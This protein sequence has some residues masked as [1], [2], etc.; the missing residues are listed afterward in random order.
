M[1]YRSF[2]LITVCIL[3][4]CLFFISLCP[5]SV[6]AEQPEKK[7][8]R[9]GWYDSAFNSVDEFGRRTG[10]GYEYQQKIAAYTGWDYEYVEGTWG[11]LFE[12]LQRGEIDILSDVSYT[13][14]RSGNM[15]FSSEPMGY[16]EYYVLIDAENT[17]IDPGNLL[18]LNGK[19]IGVNRGSLQENMFEKWLDEHDIDVELVTLSVKPS[20][21]V[22]MLKDK[23]LDAIVSVSSFDA[24]L[25]S[26]IPI[27]KIG[28]SEF[29]FA[30]NND[31]PDL[32]VELD[33]AMAQI[34]GGDVFYNRYLKEKYMSS[35][36]ILRFFSQEEK[37][38]LENHGPIRVGYR[39]EYLPFCD[40]NQESGELVGLLN[41]L[42]N[43]AS[44]GMNNAEIRFETYSY[45]TIQEALQALNSGE[46]DCLFPVCMSNYDAEVNDILITDT[47]LTSEVFVAYN[48]KDYDK[49]SQNNSVRAAVY[50]GNIDD[51]TVIKDN[52]PNWQWVVCDSVEECF[53]LVSE[54]RAECVIMSNYRTNILAEI[55]EKYELYT[56]STGIGM[57]FSFAVSSNNKVLYAIMEKLIGVVTDAQIH[58]SLAFYSL[59]NKRVTMA[60]FVKNNIAFVLIFFCIVCL[61]ICLMWVNSIIY[62]KKLKKLNAELMNKQKQLE[63]SSSGQEAQI[64][65]IK[66]LNE[67]LED[68]RNRAEAANKAK[69]S[70]L[71][72]MSHDIRTPMNAIV[73][74][75]ELILNH[76]DEKEKCID[77]TKK[78]KSSSD[79]LLSLINNVLEMA[80]IESGRIVLDEEPIQTGQIVGEVSAV[81]TELMKNKNIEFI[82]ELDVSTKYIYADKVKL[83][84]IFLN[85]VSNAYKYTPEGG[86]VF[87]TRRELPYEKEGYVM[88]ETVVSDTGIG[89]SKDFIPKIFEEF[90]RE[91]KAIDSRIQ[92]AGLGMPI[93]KRLVELMGGTITVESEI[94]KG[95]TFIVNIPHRIASVEDMHI[96]EAIAVEQ[97]KFEG[98]KILLAE[99][100]DLN[101]EIAK[102]ILEDAGFKVERAADGIICIDMLRKAK[103]NYYDLILMD[104]QMPNMDGYKA[105]RFIR[106]MEDADK[107]NIPIVA[108]TANAFEEDR[109]N[110]LAAGMNE[111]VA[112]PLDIKKLM[113]TLAFILGDCDIH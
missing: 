93:V 14:E 10:Y 108:M 9:I 7:K 50:K 79:F 75:T 18:T 47:V 58:S 46:I 13:E 106:S 2:R 24:Y 81:Y 54:D 49:F 63:E 42:I 43:T 53:K 105:T 20:E 39:E 37:E 74:Y 80:R 22:K 99:D 94:G 88:M 112:K 72:N 44:S 16:E 89:I 82:H 109:Q 68:A 34:L 70:F 12:M 38:W 40:K 85:L 59:N 101:A 41:D 57:D 23:E 11:E 66:A 36:G 98:R 86:K 104:I 111:H 29:Y 17:N 77:Y 69:S 30:V 31:R 84:E 91:T 51:E 25:E 60:D 55:I 113:E 4:I 100:N 21:Y 33:L 96:D 76:Q 78:I 87:F 48:P 35:S 97:K 67:A 6:S 26:C 110:A 27:V 32:K 5:A 62:A 83:K 90:S 95:T 92:G 107:K 56:V 28:S 71:F 103:C 1:K 52:F 61:L 102:E 73:G 3:C 45:K 64:G 65:E 19:R 8:V 15:L